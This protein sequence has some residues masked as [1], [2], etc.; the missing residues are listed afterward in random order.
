MVTEARLWPATTD[1]PWTTARETKRAE[2]EKLLESQCDASSIRG[3]GHHRACRTPS[4]P[5]RNSQ[6]HTVDS[7]AALAKSQQYRGLPYRGKCP[8]RSA[9]PDIIRGGFA[10]TVPTTVA[11]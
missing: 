4:P 5:E 6:K 1:A 8:P 10:G 11:L 2:E 7:F 3:Q 9:G